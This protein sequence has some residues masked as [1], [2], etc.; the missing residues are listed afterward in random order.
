ML[1]ATATRSALP[2]DSGRRAPDDGDIKRLAA[3]DRGLAMGL[4]V[5]KYHSPLHLRATSILKDP[6]EA[7]DLLQ[8][9][10]IRAMREPRLFLPEFELRAWLYRVTTNLCFNNVRDKRR[11]ATL[12]SGLPKRPCPKVAPASLRS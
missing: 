7:Q 12:L 8:E 11:R 10:F 5:R 3:R 1:A 4:V 9:V 6:Q 2:C